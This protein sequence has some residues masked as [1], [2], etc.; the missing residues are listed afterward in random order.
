MKNHLYRRLKTYAAKEKKPLFTGLLYTVLRT[1]M[2]IAGPLLIA[3][4]LNDYMKRT[5]DEEN[6]KR[7]ALYLALYLVAYILA[8]IFANLSRVN[9]ELAA[10]RIS[11]EVQKDAYRHIQSL[12][13]AYFDSLPAGNIASRITND[14]KR[15]KIMFQLVLGEMLTSGV[16]LVGV[17]AMMLWLYPLQAL[18]LLTLAPLVL[19]VFHD[20]RKNTRKYVTKVRRYTADLNGRLN[21]NIQNMEI[22]RAFCREKEVKE[23]FDHWN[24]L[25]LQNSMGMTKARSYGGFRGIDILSYLAT[26]LILAY[27]GFGKLTGRWAVSL[28]SIYLV[29]DY[30][31][32]IYTNLKTVVSR[33]GDMEQ[34]VIS[35][36]QVFDLWKLE[37]EEETGGPLREMKGEVAFTHVTF[38][39]DKEEVLKDIT[40]TAVPGETVAFVGPTGSGKT[41]MMNLLLRF[42]DPQQGAVTI[43]GKDLTTISRRDLRSHMATVLQDTYLFEGTLK[44]NI[45]LEGHYTDEEVEQVLRELGAE[46]LLSRGIGEVIKEQGANLSQGEKQLISFARAHIRNPKI[47]LLDE[48][49]ANIDTETEALIQRGIKKLRENRTTFLI[50]H[51]LSTVK[52]ADR[53]YVLHRGELKEQGAHEELMEQKGLY[54]KM[55]EEQNRKEEISAT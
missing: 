47:L 48:A 10:N 12:P 38:A 16:L 32:K 2:E 26:L 53:I 50:A 46:T 6:I 21:E 36:A 1:A 8:G 37:K 33:F 11:Y 29:L 45:V 31:G 28:G 51:R 34:S 42:Y 23:D 20:L 30:T 9:Y 13:I 18:L 14:T 43:D 40:L 35:A 7:I 55:V 25:I 49:T 15:L 4:I 39:Y 17:Y 41:T 24:T 22:I 5:M 19:L 54:W 3:K 27:F 52:D 44:D